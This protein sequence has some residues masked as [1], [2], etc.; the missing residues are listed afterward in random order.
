LVFLQEQDSNVAPL[1][2]AAGGD[3]KLLQ[4]DVE[5]T[6]AKLPTVTGTGA[7]MRVSTDLSKLLDNAMDLAEKSGDKFLT[8]ERVLQGMSLAKAANVA[9]LL[10]N[11]GVKPQ[12]L[13]EAINQ[14]RKG[15]TADSASSEA[16]F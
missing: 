16:Q 15:R 5:D 1:I 9:E 13:N 12:A 4:K 8:S 3:A 2:V 11:A 10:E 6:V 14:R 7:Q